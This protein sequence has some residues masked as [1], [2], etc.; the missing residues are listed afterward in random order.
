MHLVCP[1]C[2]AIN[3]VPD[4]RLTDHPVC[5]RCGAD[6]APA[7]PV[8]LNDSTLARYLEKTD[9]PVLV[10]FWADW[11]GPCKMYG[12]QFESLAANRREIRFAK[13]DSDASPHASMRFGVRS[14]PTTIL[15]QGGREVGR[16]SGALS[17]A[18]LNQWL[19]GQ[20]NK[21]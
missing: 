16:V 14:I 18:Q 15:F 6:V 7:K 9:A 5:G 12:P 4:S 20:L 13:V 17:A 3:R 8:P 2:N 19:D 11:C 1:H 21:G 10:D